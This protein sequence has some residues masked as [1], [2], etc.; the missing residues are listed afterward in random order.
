MIA[1]SDI[2]RAA[3]M[4]LSSHKSRTF[5][6]MLGIVI[7]ILSIMVV[8]SLGQ[9]ANDLILGEFQKF[10]PNNVFILPGR[11]PT[12]PSSAGST[13]LSDSLTKKDLSDLQNPGNVPEAIGVVPVVFGQQPMVYE[14]QTYTAMILGT[15]QDMAK[16][17]SLETS[18]GRFFDSNDVADRAP[19]AVLGVTTAKELFGGNDPIGRKIRINNQIM[20]IIGVLQTQGAGSFINFDKA[21]LAPYPVVQDNILGIKYFQ[22]IVVE[23]SSPEL[24][25]AMIKDVT[26]L[27]RSNHGISDPSKDDFSIQT[28]ASIAQTVGTVT[29]ILTVLLASVAAISLVVGGVGIMNI[30]LVSVTER[31]R[32]I[33][34]RK[35]L[36]ATS[37]N[38]LLQFLVE[39]SALTVLGGC[40]GVLA[41]IGLSWV[42]S[43]AANYWW[44][45]GFP[46]VISISGIVLGVVVSG[47][48][49]LAFGI[50]PAWRA[51]QKSPIEALRYE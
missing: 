23:G 12:G 17:F 24:V 10:G 44:G 14:S 50:F 38:I 13:L 30:M 28:Q 32:E 45:I 49:G 22:R 42:V 46:F 26:A 18:N 48:I 37:G 20:Q 31:T 21:V 41:G 3:L 2:G 27:L 43:L 7:G 51:A 40:V 33:G 19:V 5:L 29:S 9:G 34:L 8:M 6:T 1:V 47:V 25:P 39:A 15:N 11:Q 4:G 35:A 36:G 16:L